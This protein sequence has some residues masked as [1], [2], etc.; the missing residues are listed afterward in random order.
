MKNSIEVSIGIPFYNS[1]NFL[2]KTILSVLNQTYSNFEL[3]L[4]DDGS[5]DH[6][7]EIAKSFSDS[8]ITVISD[9]K[10][11]GI[12]YRLNEQLWLAKGKYF[13][14]MDADDLMF[15][16]RIEKQ[17]LFLESHP[18]IDIVGSQAIVI[19]DQNKI[20]GLRD[21]TVPSSIN[22]VL[23][24]PVFIHPTVTGRVEWFRKFGYS[25]ALKGVED[26]DLWIRS[27]SNSKFHKLNEPLLFYRDPLQIKLN[28]YRFRQQQLR[29][30]LLANRDLFRGKKISPLISIKSYLK[31]FLF[32]VATIL[33]LDHILLSRR[34]KRIDKNMTSY[35]NLLTNLLI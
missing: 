24:N 1:E 23:R 35:V 2:K 28:I 29:I 17:V 20:L 22:D 33:N 25:N 14:R 32:Q 27:F 7:L 18:E 16:V 12:A 21:S 9:G 5:S 6:S 26:L 31:T 10:N 3:I 11:K 30:C 15:P 34:N 19:D 4:S 13:A 8:R